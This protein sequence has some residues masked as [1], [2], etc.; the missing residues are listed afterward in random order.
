MPDPLEGAI[1]LNTEAPAPAPAS[2]RGTSGGAPVVMNRMN[3][4]GLGLENTAAPTT[5]S[6]TQLQ[7]ESRDIQATKD[8]VDKALTIYRN[9]IVPKMKRGEIG[10]LG[11]Y[12]AYK[13]PA[14]AEKT[15]PRMD[16]D[17]EQFWNLLGMIQPRITKA[18]TSRLGSQILGQLGGGG[19]GHI[20]A[21]PNWPQTASFSREGH[22]LED[23]AANLPRLLSALQGAP[24]PTGASDGL[25]EDAISLPSG[26]YYSPSTKKV[27]KRVP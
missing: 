6:I 22:D 19:S 4:R 24:P 5:A 17:V 11:Q 23:A 18:Y 16:R 21:P 1:P 26:K 14:F 7:E 10:G 13:A 8:L 3:F 27:Y 12:Y 9:R 2:K 20:P 15:G 25:P